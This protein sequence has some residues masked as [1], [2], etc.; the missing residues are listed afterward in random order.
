MQYGELQEASGMDEREWRL[1]K[2]YRHAEMGSVIAHLV[3]V[4][5]LI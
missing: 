4:P 5:F 1:T 3:C 2:S